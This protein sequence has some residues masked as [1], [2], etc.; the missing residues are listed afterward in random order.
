M[1][2]IKLKRGSPVLLSDNGGNKKNDKVSI[3][4]SR[5]YPSDGLS[6][7]LLNG[8]NNRTP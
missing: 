5:Y 1:N 8:R 6:G 2:V 7:S 4:E 3:M